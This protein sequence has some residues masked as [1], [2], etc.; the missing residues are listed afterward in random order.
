MNCRSSLIVGH[1]MMKSK[2]LGCRAQM[3]PDCRD[4]CGSEAS[5]GEVRA[6]SPGPM[7]DTA[8][9]KLFPW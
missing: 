4:R 8:L 6:G 5:E 3:F 2:L 1:A 9:E 7:D